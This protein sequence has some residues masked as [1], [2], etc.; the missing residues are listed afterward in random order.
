MATESVNF[1]TST[2]SKEETKHCH[3]SK[4]AMNVLNKKGFF[5]GK[6]LSLCDDCVFGKHKRV[7]FKSAVHCT[8]GVL[9]YIHSDLWG[10]SRRV[11]LGGCNYLLTFIAD[12]YRKV[13]CFFINTK[14]EVMGVF[15]DWKTMVEKR[16]EHEIKT[17]RIDNGLAFV[18]NEFL[19]GGYSKA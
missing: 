17:L 19:K 3:M 12:Y 8:K 14:D 9:D 11:S 15:K 2:M 13:W 1:T 6:K 4:Q 16:M 5:G 7:S 10:P 18:D